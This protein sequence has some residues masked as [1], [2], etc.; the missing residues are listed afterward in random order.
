MKYPTLEIAILLSSFSM[1]RSKDGFKRSIFLHEIKEIKHRLKIKGKDYDHCE[2]LVE[3]DS[4][5]IM[6]KDREIAPPVNQSFDFFVNGKFNRFPLDLLGDGVWGKSVVDSLQLLYCGL[7]TPEVMESN[8]E[9]PIW[10]KYL[11]AASISFHGIGPYPEGYAS[12]YHNGK[13]HNLVQS[14]CGR[15]SDQPWTMISMPER[16]TESQLA[17]Y[18]QIY[19]EFQKMHKALTMVCPVTHEKSHRAVAVS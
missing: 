6:V 19:A 4:L 9:Q 2:L 11:D 10:I 7:P 16:C 12:V 18:L 5:R 8:N 13:A 15:P 1:R 14:L 3:G 17:L